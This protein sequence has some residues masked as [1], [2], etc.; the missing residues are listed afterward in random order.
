MKRMGNIR[1]IILALLVAVILVSLWFDNISTG[2]FLYI[3]DEYLPLTLR[4]ALNSLFVYS[5]TNFGSPSSIEIIVTF[6]DR[7]F[8]LLVYAFNSSI[9]FAEILL[10]A[11]KVVLIIT[12][13]FFGFK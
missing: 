11:I 4:E 3:H 10:Y 5:S 2:Q 12:I 13:P 8:Y 7:I 9:Y 6:F 1:I